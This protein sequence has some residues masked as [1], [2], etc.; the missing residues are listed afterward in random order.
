MMPAAISGFN[1]FWHLPILIVLIS[2]VYSATR[3]DVWGAILVE[4]FRWGLR[5]TAFLGG[6]GVVLFLLNVFISP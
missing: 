5:M 4:A 3:Y 1:L 2:L 6:I